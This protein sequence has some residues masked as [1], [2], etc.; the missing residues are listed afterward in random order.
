METKTIGGSRAKLADQLPLKT[1]FL[2]QMFP[3][4]ACNCKCEFC[5]YSLEKSKHG[6]MSDTI[7]MDYKLYE[8]FVEDMSGYKTKMLRFAGTGEPLIH[9]NIADMVA[10]A[11]K[12]DIAERVD[13]VTNGVLLNQKLSDDLINANLDTLR[14]SVNGLTSQD[15]KKHCDIN[16]NFDDFVA[17]IKYF[18]ENKKETKVYIKIIDYMV[19]T[20]ELEDKFYSIFKPICDT[21]NIENLVEPV[22][23]V[24]VSDLGGD[25]TKTQNGENL[26][27]AQV[28][29][30]PFYMLQINPDGKIVPCCAM[31]YPGILGDINNEKIIDIFTGDK[32]NSFRKNLLLGNKNKICSKC[33]VYKY[34][35]Y[36]E[37]ILDNDIDKL[38][39]LF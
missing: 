23:S 27:D 39:K 11:K 25:L 2:I 37:D 31:E 30:Q 18:Y 29:P 3:V 5:I 14:I 12:S 17:N 4:Y 9:K 6:F 24:D 26:S 38:L 19:N 20:K 34:G 10:L 33:V 32:F 16:M 21:I 36:Q 28:C 7:N 1:P 22:D 13:I 35:I 8:K 15:Y